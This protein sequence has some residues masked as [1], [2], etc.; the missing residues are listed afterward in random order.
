MRLDFGVIRRA[1][2]NGCERDNA[3]LNAL[4]ERERAKMVHVVKRFRRDLI[5]VLLS[6]MDRVF[7]CLSL[8]LFL[9]SGF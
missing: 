8:E 5:V 2:V 7:F 1:H 3:A 4:R 6:L 9:V